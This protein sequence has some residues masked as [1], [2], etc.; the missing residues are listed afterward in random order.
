MLTRVRRACL[1]G[2]AGGGGGGVPAAPKIEHPDT[3]F[4]RATTDYAADSESCLLLVSCCL[5]SL[6]MPRAIA[7]D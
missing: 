6:L 1:Q 2:G 5:D 7:T 4:K 3:G